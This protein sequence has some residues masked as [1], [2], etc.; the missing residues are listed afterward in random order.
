M[1]QAK[2]TTSRPRAT[3]PW[4]SE[5]TLPCS[6]LTAAA[7]RSLLARSSSRNRNRTW[8]RLDSE[9][10]RQPGKAAFAVATASPTSSAPA[11]ATVPVTVPDAGS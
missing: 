10:S 1:P 7:S 6:E 4:A 5:N 2:S 11:R 9:V 8:T 3:S